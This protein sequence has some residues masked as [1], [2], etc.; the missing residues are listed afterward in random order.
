MT[1][2]VKSSDSTRY[3]VRLEG[4]LDSKWS[5]WL[6]PMSISIEGDE[7][8]LAGEISDQAAL[9]GLLIRIRDL[10]LKLLCLESIGREERNE[11]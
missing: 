8:I 7:T 6:Y 5:E 10:N 11:E 9:H 2:H 1:N 3:R 4:R